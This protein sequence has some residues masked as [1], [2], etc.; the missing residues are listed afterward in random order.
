MI[1]NLKLLKKNDEVLAKVYLS[2][3]ELEK[4]RDTIID[5][6]ATENIQ[7]SEDLKNL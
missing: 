2:N 5:I 7:K 1:N 6:I 3:K 4:L